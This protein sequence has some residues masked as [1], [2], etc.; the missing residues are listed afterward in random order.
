MK[1]SALALAIVGAF[2]VGTANALTIDDFSTDQSVA[3]TSAAPAADNNNVVAG[4]GNPRNLM[5]DK[6]VGPAGG[7][8]GAFADVIGG[9]LSMA[10]GPTTE[11]TITVTWSAIAAANADFT[12]AGQST[13]IFFSLPDPID[14]DLT[15]TFTANGTS[16]Y[17]VTFPNGSAGND[18]FAPFSEFDD[19]SV[20]TSMSTLSIAFT[21]PAAWDANID[22]VETR[23]TP[24]PVP[25]TLALFGLGLAGLARRMKRV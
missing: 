8:N 3:V 12:D 17:S 24:V 21:G 6:T 10:N 25:G 16:T 23:P 2:A 20:F 1:R 11:S 14:N 19:P 15:V 5:V 4:I 9:A 22:L 7:A 18:F 13:G